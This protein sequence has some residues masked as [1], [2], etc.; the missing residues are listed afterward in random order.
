[1]R[2]IWKFPVKFMNTNKVQ[3]K[4]LDWLH[5]GFD[6]QGEICV[7]AVVD[8]LA[9][10]E[11]EKTYLIELVGTGHYFD[12]DFYNTADYIGTTNDGPYV[13]HVFALEVE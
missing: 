12:K 5:V 13:W 8:P 9:A 11:Q 4:V 7:W 1:M 3:A 2:T 6:P 10:E